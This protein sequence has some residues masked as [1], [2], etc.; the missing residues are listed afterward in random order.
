MLVVTNIN[1]RM[2][3][4]HQYNILKKFCKIYDIDIYFKNE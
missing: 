2:K 1:Q 4:L 3:D